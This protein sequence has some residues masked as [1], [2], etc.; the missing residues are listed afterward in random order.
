MRAGVSYP[1]EVEAR[2]A[3]PSCGSRGLR[4]FYEIAQIPAQSCLVLDHR[5]DAM[6]VPRVDLRLA[7]CDACGFV[8]NT[9]FDPG[10]VEYSKR[11]EE[12]QGFS[13]TFGRF[14]RSLAERLMDR[15]DL[16]GKTVMEIGCGKGEFLTLL[17]ELGAGKGIG[18]DPAYIPERNTSP[19]ADKVDVIDAFFD[20][21]HAR[22][23]P[24]VIICRHTLEHIDDVHAFLTTLRRAIGERDVD[25]FF[26]V[27]DAGRVIGEPAYLDIYNEHCSYF[28][29]RSLTN[30]FMAAG[31]DVTET[32]LEYADQYLMLTARPGKGEHRVTP[33]LSMQHA[34]Q[35][36]APRCRPL[37]EQW[38]TRIGRCMGQG[39]RVVVWGSGSKCVAFMSTLGITDEIDYVIDI[40]PHRQGTFMPG[41]LPRIE[42]PEHVLNAPP[43]RVIVMNPVY[44]D[45]IRRHLA[46][47]GLSPRLIAA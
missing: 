20:E 39:E 22:L 33:D 17:C 7:A 36:F 24:D 3:C 47:L 5:R 42:A 34:V 29:A 23:E 18:I 9:R 10:A 12:T 37:I 6:E 41:V 16:A 27:P 13:P 21:S 25:V 15:F 46:D 28:T 14:A 45:E 38:Q 30:A 31:F 1:W 8:T 40:N 19:G 11:Y 4:A 44:L 2:Q 43:D 26:E 32:W 35:T